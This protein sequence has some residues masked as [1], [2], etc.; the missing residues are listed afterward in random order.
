[1][2]SP[3]TN[4]RNLLEEVAVLGYKQGRRS[5]KKG[6]RHILKK[7]SFCHP[8]QFNYIPDP[9]GKHPCDWCQS[10]FFGFYGLT[11]ETGPR[12]VEG[13]YLE[14]GEGFEEVCGGFADPGEDGMQGRERTRMCVACTFEV[15]PRFFPS[16]PLPSPFHFT[17][18]IQADEISREYAS[19]P[20][21]P[22]LS[23]PSHSQSKTPPS[24]ISQNGTR[25]S[26]LWKQMTNSV[27][28][29]C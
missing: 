24:G 16:L 7:T 4:T 25:L 18:I 8:I 28:R 23:A 1:M 6:N 29:W 14:Y 13:Y 12:T 27:A 3:K 5:L 19:S 2:S 26:Q 17:P 11:D 22:T 9:M 10:P 15:I 20:A 21:P